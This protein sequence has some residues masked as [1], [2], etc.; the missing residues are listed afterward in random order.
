MAC[1]IAPCFHSLVCWE[2]LIN[3]KARLCFPYVLVFVFLTTGWTNT[4]SYDEREHLFATLLLHE[5]IWKREAA[6]NQIMQ[7][8]ALLDVLD[9]VRKYPSQFRSRFVAS[10]TAITSSQLMEQMTIAE[11]SN[12]AEERAKT[13]FVQYIQDNMSI[14]CGEGNYDVEDTDYKTSEVEKVYMYKHAS[15]SVKAAGNNSSRKF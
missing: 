7:G 13:F 8:L 15:R 6:I 2:I 3:F 12:S 10:T 9:L 14:S 5:I 1:C 11:P 4:I